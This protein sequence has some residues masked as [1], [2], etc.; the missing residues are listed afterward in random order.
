MPKPYKAPLERKTAY[1]DSLASDEGIHLSMLTWEFELPVI[2]INISF[3]VLFNFQINLYLGLNLHFDLPELD[4]E[5]PQFGDFFIDTETGLTFNKIDLV[6]KAKYGISRY[7]SS[8]YD[9]EQVSSKPLQR[10]LW[11]L[12][13]KTTDKDG[14][15]VKLTS[16]AAKSWINQLKEYLTNKEVADFYQDAMFEILA[17]IEGKLATTSYWDFAAFDVSVFGEEDKFKSRFTDDWRTDKELE[18]VG[19][20][21]VHF[22]YC[23][24]G[25]ARFC[26]DYEGGSI[27]VKEELGDDLQKRIDDFHKRSGFV[28]QY[29]EKTIYQRVFFYQKKDKMHDKGGHHQIRLQNLKNHVKQMLNQEGVIAQFRTAYLAFAQELYY[30]YYEPHRK[31]KQWKKIL[32]SDELINKY[33]RMG[34]EVNL[35]NK[36][37][38][39]VERWM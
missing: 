37:K 23:R 12:R 5:I 31:Y 11:D 16:E 19:V 9:P 28:E 25:Y 20:Y 7:N 13:Y 32:S 35:L 1:V 10:L 8:I 17:L 33:K 30:L 29:G 22:D 27:E 38:E 21:D 6:D 39:V 2:Q 18:T 3:N 36:I 34:C 26:E 15:T 14:A 24:F 4:F